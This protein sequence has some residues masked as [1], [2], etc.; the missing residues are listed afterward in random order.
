MPFPAAFL[1]EL[2]ARNPIDEVVG[3]Y[4][5]LTR[6]GANL[7]GLCP[8]HA[9]KTASFS[10]T[11]DKQLY[12][13]FG[14]HRGGGVIQFIMEEEGLDYA[15]AVR[16]LARRAGME[17]PE[18]QNHASAYRRQE[19]LRAL[20]KDAARHYR[21]ELYGPA[22][23]DA[24][25][26]LT[27]RGVSPKTAARFGLGF[28]PEGW[29]GLLDAMCRK[30]Y[31][32]QDLLDAGLLVKNQKGGVYDRFRNRL[33]FPIIDV[34]GN[35][36]GFGGRVMDDS[37]PKYLNSPETSIFNK[38][39]NLFALNVAK[40]S[41]QGRI[42]L[43]EG[44]MDAIALHQYGFDC[45][46][47]S[48]GTSLTE[49]HATILAKYTRQVVI[50]YDGDEAGQNATR[51][52]IGMLENTGV[53]VRVL[54]MQGAKDPD[55]FLKAYGADRFKLLLEQSENH[56]AYGL[57]T[58]RRKYDLTQDEQRVAFLREAAAF[59]AGLSGAVEREV[60]GVRAAELGGITAGAMQ[61][62]VDKA[63]R[64]RRAKEKK[65]QER[66]DLAPA[67]AQQPH[68]REIH[69]DNV[70]SAMAEESLLAM[71][72]REPALF[73]RCADLT[74]EQFSAPLL[75]RTYGLLRRRW[76]EGLQVGLAALGETFT[77]GEL[78]HLS[79][80][81]QKRDSLI[82]DQAADDCIRTIREEYDRSRV[83]APE[84]LLDMRRRLQQKKGYGGTKA[85]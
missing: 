61:L 25:A 81:A 82:S 77:S 56:A 50:T 70:R 40:K 78:S 29:S 5:H 19:H 84:D 37:S 71:L 7:F 58:L 51:R 31:E 44:Y 27:R 14:C 74:A 32:K 83:A 1:D 20:C 65:R 33:M 59:V 47:A 60:Y 11:P 13:C 34:S 17:V 35:V 12:Y 28:A 15:D 72:L 49:E 39:K 68:S 62:E 45:A 46:V 24:R 4:V 43:T 75:G 30:G 9:E 85:W 53:Q 79:A 41:K 8:F 26:Y 57:E 52:A 76:E 10:V 16:F 18:D 63:L 42:I 69:Y 73:A 80:V 23:Q 66:R 6:K 55:E 54:R 38:R 22:G 36:I 2:V 64:Q 21:D 3:Q 67:A 48:L